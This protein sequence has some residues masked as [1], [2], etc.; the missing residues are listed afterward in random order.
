MSLRIIGNTGGCNAGTCPTV[1]ETDSGDLLVQG[2]IVED[3]GI[4]DELG[5][6][7]RGEG[8]V[9]VPR[10]LLISLVGGE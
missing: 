9:R 7:P 1:Y 5:D 2:F 3:P 6:L 8:V 4:I 10:E